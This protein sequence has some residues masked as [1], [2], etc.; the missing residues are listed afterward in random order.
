MKRRIFKVDC[1]GKCEDFRRLTGK[2]EPQNWGHCANGNAT[3]GEKDPLCGE[4]FKCKF[5]REKK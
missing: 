5:Y 3:E 1:C 2:K 4:L